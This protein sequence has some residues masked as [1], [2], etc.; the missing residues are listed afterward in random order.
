MDVGAEITSGAF[1]SDGRNSRELLEE[2]G[3]QADRLESLRN[4][5]G[6]ARA[7]LAASVDACRGKRFDIFFALIGWLV[8]SILLG[9]LA[10]L[11]AAAVEMRKPPGSRM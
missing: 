11:P 2:V 7:A 9:L 6:E 1:S 10:A 5:M 4:A 3:G 8:F